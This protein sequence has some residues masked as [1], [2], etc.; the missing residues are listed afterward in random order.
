MSD[1]IIQCPA[2]IFLTSSGNPNS[3]LFQWLFNDLNRIYKSIRSTFPTHMHNSHWA[4][5]CRMF[6]LTHISGSESELPGQPKRLI[7]TCFFDYRGHWDIWGKGV[8][9]HA[10]G[11][12]AS[13]PIE[14][15]KHVLISLKPSKSHLALFMSGMKILFLDDG[16]R[17]GL[18]QLPV[19]SRQT[20]PTLRPALPQLSEKSIVIWRQ[21]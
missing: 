11:C 14:F 2:K 3:A 5:R 15:I 19:A 4:N 21:K 7:L 6:I 20:W 1:I 16:E 17:P 8:A 18:Q 13:Q 10:L 9:S 12:C